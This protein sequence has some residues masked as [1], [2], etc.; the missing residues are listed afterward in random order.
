MKKNTNTLYIIEKQ[1]QSQINFYVQFLDILTFHHFSTIFLSRRHSNNIFFKS[2]VL[3]SMFRSNFAIQIF[4]E[5]LTS[6]ERT[7]FPL[8]IN[9]ETNFF[10]FQKFN[11]FLN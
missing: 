10:A 4:P 11:H 1:P 5:I 8:Q 3:L 7:F 2:L 6:K 9:F